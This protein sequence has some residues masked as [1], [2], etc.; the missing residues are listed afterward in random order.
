[1]CSKKYSLMK[2]NY[3]LDENSAKLLLER[4][5]IQDENGKLK[6][7]RDLNVKNTVIKF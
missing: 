4:S 1:M 6:F 2:A 5:L 3:H 7:S